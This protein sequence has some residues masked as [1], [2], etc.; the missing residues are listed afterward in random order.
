M[1]LLMCK[2]AFRSRKQVSVFDLRYN[3]LGNPEGTSCR[4]LHTIRRRVRPHSLYWS[5]SRSRTT[6]THTDKC[7]TNIDNKAGKVFDAKI[8]EAKKARQNEIDSENLN[9]NENPVSWTCRSTWKRAAVNTSWCL[10]GCSIGEFGTLAAFQVYYGDGGIVSPTFVTIVLPVVNGLATSM[11]LETAIL[12]YGSSN[13]ALPEA[14]KTAMGMSFISMVSM[15]IAMEITDYA[16]T[17]GMQMQAWVIAPM[18]LMG[19]VTPLPFN[20]WRLKKYGKSCH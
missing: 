8:E 1:S 7:N 6:T 9:L 15:E 20:Y 5:N 10:L 2:L 16:L 11:A 14:F 17:G 19:F 13:L 12:R 4:N 3:Y 18:L